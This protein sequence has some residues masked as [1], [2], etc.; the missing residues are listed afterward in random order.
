MTR[1]TKAELLARIDACEAQC[2]AHIRTIDALTAERDAL[3]I[4]QRPS[5]AHA[6][7]PVPT[8]TNIT[9]YRER[10][11]AAKALAMRMG[12]SVKL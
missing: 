7:A 3:L 12:T 9:P 5:R 11:A 6:P 1:I 2:A 10:L 4:A 8:V